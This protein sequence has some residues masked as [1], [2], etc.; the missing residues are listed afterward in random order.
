MFDATLFRLSTSEQGTFGI[1]VYG[2]QYLYTGELPWK[3]NKRNVS[4]IP[5]GE[6]NVQ[7]RLSPKYG[8]VYEVDVTGRTYILFHQGNFCGDLSRGFRTH[9]QGCILLGFKR[10][11]LYGQQAVLGSR[12]ARGR[13]E[14][15]LNFEPFTLEIKECY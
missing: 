1:L 7:V 6:Y 12:P 15:K 9:V 3:G 13:F 11:T 8:Q 10:G 14:R 5:T 2:S 4:C